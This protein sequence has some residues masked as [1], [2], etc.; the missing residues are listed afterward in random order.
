MK[1]VLQQDG[2]I[3]IPENIH[4]QIGWGSRQPNLVKD[5]PAHYRGIRPDGL[6]KS[7]LTQAILYFYK[8][9]TH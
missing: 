1:Q 9:S 2:E 4:F 8:K 6:S 5:I 3:L 7:L